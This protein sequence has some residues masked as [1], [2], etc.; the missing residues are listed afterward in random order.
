MGIKKEIWKGVYITYKDAKNESAGL[1]F[2]SDRWI[3]TACNKVIAFREKLSK[4]SHPS[5]ISNRFSSLPLLISS[6]SNNNNKVSILDFGG[7]PGTQYEMLKAYTCDNLKIDYSIVETKET[8]LAGRRLFKNDRNISFHTDFLS[9]RSNIQIAYSNSAI[10]YIDDWE[11][12]IAKMV[13]NNPDYLLLDDVP[14]G[15]FESFTA[16]QDYYGSRIPHRFFNIDETVE[17][18]S[19]NGYNLV[20]KSKYFGP[21]LGSFS[22]WPMNN[23][24][25]NHKL[26][27]SCSL[28]FK[29]KEG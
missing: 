5:P 15:D 3:E 19:K 13:E 25:N 17:K 2:S 14:A 12:V 1:G 21:V 18:I 22:I 29:I 7:G 28:L 16:L 8:V 26:D 23:F 11:A 27:Y 9:V 24:D 4:E 20:Y 6:I 10:Q